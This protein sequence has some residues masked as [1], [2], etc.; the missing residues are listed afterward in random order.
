MYSPFNTSFITAVLRC[1]LSSIQVNIALIQQQE[2]VYLGNEKVLLKVKELK[3]C[4][5]HYMISVKKALKYES[6]T[7]EVKQSRKVFYALKSRIDRFILPKSYFKVKVPDVEKI[8][9]QDIDILENM[10]ADQEG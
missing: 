6:M 8:T 7:I 4:C 5:F 3:F 10:V 1:E 9:V 2:R